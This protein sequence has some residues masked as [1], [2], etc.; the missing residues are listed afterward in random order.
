LNVAAAL[1]EVPDATRL[2]LE[3]EAT[4]YLPEEAT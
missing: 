2:V 4:T 3:E 1:V